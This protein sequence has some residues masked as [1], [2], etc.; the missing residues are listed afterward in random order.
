LQVKNVS[1]LIGADICPI[2]GNSR[3]FESGDAESL[4]HDLLPEFQFAGLVIANLECPLIDKASPI[5]KT[6]PVF[7]ESGA[8][9]NGIRAAGI[10]V[11]S[12][13]NNHILD[14]G[15]SGLAH[16]L[17]VCAQ[18]GI[19]TV[20]AGSNLAAA[21][22]ILVKEVDGVRV[23]I[24]AMA[25]QEFSIATDSSPG[26]NP[27]DL[28]DY[29]RNV[30]DNR[31]TI[32]YLIVLLH[33]GPEFLTAP[34]PRLKDTCHFL[35]EMGANTVVVQHPHS[36]GG[37]ENYLGGHIVY[38]QGALVMDEAIYRG[39]KSFHE[40]VLVALRIAP[41]GTS[42]MELVPFVQSDPVPGARRMD[43]SRG[44]DFLRGLAAKSQAIL[45]DGHVRD[46]WRRFC[47]ERK[48]GYL[49][50]LFAHNRLLRRANRHGWLTRMLYSRRRLLGTRNLVCCE[51]HR[52]AL[53]TIFKERLV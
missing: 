4:F 37:Y 47:D 27:L 53:E 40:G 10:D 45:D 15:G 52:E 42:S 48:H 49:S 19:A 39:L 25:E 50:A 14:H 1:V 33:G 5:A 9:I 44:E 7:G 30:R 26:A 35:I 3:Y 41:G 18:A 24:M 23:G 46:E 12:L 22:R 32:D 29:V 17:T 11:V 43:Q 38:G 6:G 21:R 8:C 28:I 2:G 16:T 36:L 34:S 20:G 31:D 51:T 13:A